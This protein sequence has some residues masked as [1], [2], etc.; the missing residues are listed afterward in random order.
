MNISDAAGFVR[1]LED[2]QVSLL[3]ES[4]EMDRHITEL[5][6]EKHLLEEKR[7][8]TELQ[9]MKLQTHDRINAAPLDPDTAARLQDLR[10]QHE[11]LKR[12]GGAR[13]GSL[14]EQRQTVEKH[15]NEKVERLQEVQAELEDIKLRTNWEETAQ[16][17]AAERDYRALEN[18]TKELKIKLREMEDEQQIA[19]SISTKK[20][21]LIERL[22]KRL[23]DL[24]EIEEQCLVAK[25]DLKQKNLAKADTAEDIKTLKRIHHKKEALMKGLTADHQKNDPV[26]IKRLEADKKVLQHEIQ[27]AADGRRTMDKTIQA[28]HRRLLALEGKLATMSSALRSLNKYRSGEDAAQYRPEVPAGAEEVDAVLYE[29][30][31]GRLTEARRGL[32]RKDRELLE[33]DS[34]IEE[35]SQKVDIH[36][37]AMR[38]MV[39]R[40]EMEKGVMTSYERMYRDAEREDEVRQSENRTFLSKTLSQ[41]KARSQEVK[42]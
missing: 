9:I 17:P 6:R 25:D 12:V 13:T 29:Q 35:L 14:V 33:S 10:N 7:T 31:Q 11:L 40:L 32:A 41:A 2:K 26:T 19:K 4:K 20:T 21:E 36:M 23:Q 30:V 22:S 34:Q 28:Q 8:L 3:R 24:R 38:S 1:D 27:K 42:G 39:R 15:Y 37:H 5:Q 18:R 16:K